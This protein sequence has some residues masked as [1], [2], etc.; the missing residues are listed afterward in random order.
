M[1]N[2]SIP[3]INAAQFIDK[4][5]INKA[6]A[7]VKIGAAW[8]ASSHLLKTPLHELAD[9]FNGQVQFFQMDHDEEA[10][11]TSTYRVES[12]PTILFFKRGTLVDKLTGLV[13][14]NTISKSIDQLVQ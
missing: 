3:K 4:I 7:L 6:D 11:L 9:Q 14:K 5:L 10:A 12:V 1:E 2:R 8:S 13:Q